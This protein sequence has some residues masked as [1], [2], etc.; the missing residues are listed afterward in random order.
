MP[1]NLGAGWGGVSP[2][3]ELKY[4]TGHCPKRGNFITLHVLEI[5]PSVQADSSLGYCQTAV[6][7]QPWLSSVSGYA[8]SHEA[9][10]GQK[11]E[12]RTEEEACIFLGQGRSQQA[13]DGR[14]YPGG[15]GL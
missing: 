2:E 11:H 8:V 12:V 9:I 7:S 5:L 4:M 10:S 3:E 6:C 14:W 1:G 15:Q 13:R